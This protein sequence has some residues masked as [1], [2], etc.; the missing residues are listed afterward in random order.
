MDTGVLV[1]CLRG[2]PETIAA[3]KDLTEEGDLHISVWSEVEILTLVREAQEKRTLEFMTPFIEHPVTEPIAQRA[4][5]LRRGDAPSK[6]SMAQALIAATAVQ[7]G[8]TLVTY[9]SGLQGVE[10]LKLHPLLAAA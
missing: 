2:L 9:D 6:L 7:H 4:A 3:A 1:R 5:A 8:L 10:G